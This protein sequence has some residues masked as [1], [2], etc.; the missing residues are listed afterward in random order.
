M[1]LRLP[2]R[3]ALPSRRHRAMGNDSPNLSETHP[4][5]GRG[6]PD[7]AVA[8]YLTREFSGYK[9]AVFAVAVTRIV[10]VTVALVFLLT[11]TWPH[12]YLTS[13]ITALFILYCGVELIEAIRTY[14][15]M[16]WR[17]IEAGV[18]V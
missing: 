4:D 7:R 13:F 16:R 3:T 9:A 15:Q 5:E 10:I 12:A 14:R 2:L 18:S 17:L 1:A 11:A 6:Y 8:K